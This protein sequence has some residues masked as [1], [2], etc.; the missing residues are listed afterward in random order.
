[1]GYLI[2][3]EMTI[4]NFKNIDK[5]T[6]TFDY[7]NNIFGKNGLGKTTIADA[8]F[9]VMCNRNYTLASDP[10][11][12]PENRVVETGPHVKLLCEIAKKEVTIEKRQ[13]KTEKLNAVG[14][15][16]SVSLNSV[17]TVND[18]PMTQADFKS[19]L[20]EMG[21]SENL[22][23]PL[24]HPD[25]FLENLNLKK[26]REQIRS[27]L[28]KLASDLDDKAIADKYPE[29]RPLAKELENCTL[30]EVEAKANSRIKVINDEYGKEGE[31][32]VAKVEALKGAQI[33]KKVI[34]NAKG[35]CEMQNAKLSD[36]IAKKEEILARESENNAKA[37]RVVILQKQLSDYAVS[38][39]KEVAMM[40]NEIKGKIEVEETKRRSLEKEKEGNRTLYYNYSE[41]YKQCEEQAKDYKRKWDELNQKVFDDKDCKCPT[42]GQKYP[43]S[44]LM[45]L[46]KKFVENLAKEKEYVLAEAKRLKAKMDKLKV[47]ANKYV[48]MNDAIDHKI[49]ECNAKI[50]QLKGDFIRLPSGEDISEDAEYKRI[51]D[52]IKAIQSEIVLDET[53]K[54]QL[55]QLESEI[56]ELKNDIINDNKTIALD[57]IN[58]NIEA[59]IKALNIKKREMSN[60]KIKMMGLKHQIDVL[61]MKKNSEIEEQINSFFNLVTWKLF[62]V[63]KNGEVK[64][65]CTPLIDGYE[66]GST[67]NTGREILAKLDI[68]ATLQ[69]HYELKLPVF[70]DNAESLSADTKERIKGIEQIIFLNVT[71]DEELKIKGGNE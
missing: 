7:Q 71:E 67:T 30:K 23:L 1:M 10:K 18:I 62:R 58:K 4:E 32:I 56:N 22:I 29:L 28:F 44:K 42:C 31:I 59:E 51:Q 70:V 63:Q 8:F 24:S 64:N 15:V 57:E 39:N 54:V 20:E 26:E 46:Q 36:L 33:G 14:E 12:Y 49:G 41:Q 65:D 53:T 16:K 17:Y 40:E 52:E 43:S 61:G 68:I 47:E 37:E 66:F 6:I 11:I 9:W 34:D 45:E 13:K 38:R 35:R 27:V 5:K 50:K 21:I 60:E 19:K 69:K 48:E 2:L 3:K 25:A 55:E